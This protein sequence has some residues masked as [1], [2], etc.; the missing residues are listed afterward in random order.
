MRPN[1]L[2]VVLDAARRDALEPYGAPPGSTPAIAQLARRG[3]AAAHA[4]ATGSWTVPSHASL[5]TG[6]LP[7][8]L[9]LAQPPDGTAHSCRPLLERVADRLLPEALR[10]A[11]YAT[12]GYSAN[13]WVSDLVGFDLGFE[14]F[15]YLPGDREARLGAPLTRGPR[16][17][18]AWA[19]EGLRARSDDGAGEI[20]RRLRDSIARWTGRPTFW[21]VNLVECH[22]PYLPPRPWNDLPAHARLRAAGDASRYLSFEAICLHAAGRLRVPERSLE[23]MRHLYRR[24]VA[25]LDAWLADVLEALDRRGALEQ[26]LV[27]VTSDHGENLGEDGLLAHGFSLDER[28]IHVP[29]VSAGPG[30]I[31][32]DQAFSLARLPGRIAHACGLAPD[33][34]AADQPRPG[35]AVSEYDPM[36]AADDERVQAFA[37]RWRLGDRELERLTARLTSATDGHY[38]LLVKDGA[39]VLYDLARDP[40]ERS[41]VTEEPPGDV[42]AS[43]RGAVAASLSARAS[44]LAAAG[45]AA[46]PP[47]DVAALER[48]MRLLGYL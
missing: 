26:T 29:L 34:W 7:R 35:I 3:H 37:R 28:L 47:D 32:C 20:G 42:V 25:Y 45:T 36:G 43:L 11:G 6:M 8:A 30:A 1:V 23:R 10:R 2:L 48:Q 39:E 16:A 33:P 15:E 5:L 41:P 19:L 12:H 44:T 24:A 14:R 46:R 31:T 18:L 13:L 17:R 38:K 40:R 4:Y 9:G 22:S 27:I 21:F